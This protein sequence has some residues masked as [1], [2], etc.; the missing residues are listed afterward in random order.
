MASSD[1]SAR[2][3]AITDVVPEFALQVRQAIYAHD[4]LTPSDMALVFAVARKAGREPCAEWSDVFCDALTDYVV[5]QNAPADYIPREKAD[6]LIAQLT[7]AGGISSQTEFKMFI[8]IITDALGVP[9]S[10]AT[11]A[12]REI[13][14]AIMNGRRD[15][16]TDADHPAGV[17]TKADVAALRA[18]LFAAKFGTVDHVTKEEAEVLF[19]IAHAT[20][21]AQNDPSFDDLFARSVGNYL[22]AIALHSPDAAEALRVEK[23]LDEKETL[24]GFF[25]RMLPI[26]LPSRRD[27]EP[28]W[29]VYG[30]DLAKRNAAD[31]ALRHESK[32]ITD[33]EAAWVIAHLT[34]DGQLTSAERRLLQFLQTEATSIAPSL[35][36]LIDNQTLAPAS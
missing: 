25:A 23:W 17:V 2:L 28:L 12:L 6:W 8:A 13:A 35:R 5:H 33:S 34:R 32:A 22:M 30:D 24:T 18:V 15:A 11:F 26:A 31:A 29:K 19:D 1:L 4:P 36:E 7:Q 16:F 20:A 3:A 21:H 14:A 27:F 10:L 9:T